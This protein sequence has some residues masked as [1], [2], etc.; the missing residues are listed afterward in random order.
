MIIPFMMLQSCP[1][2]CLTSKVLTKF[3]YVLA[4]NNL[5]ITTEIIFLSPSIKNFSPTMKKL[6]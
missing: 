1:C 3:V 5:C 4:S 2:L 6:I